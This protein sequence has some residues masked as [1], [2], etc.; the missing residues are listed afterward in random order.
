[1]GIYNTVLLK[2]IDFIDDLISCL[3]WRQLAAM[4]SHL[5]AQ[6]SFLYRTVRWRAQW[7][8]VW[9]R[10]HYFRP[11]AVRWGK[12]HYFR[13][14][15]VRWGKVHYFRPMAARWGKVRY[16]RQMAV[17]QGKTNYPVPAFHRNC[18]RFQV[19]ELSHHGNRSIPGL[20]RKR[21]PAA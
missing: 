11:M 2:D 10:A 6:C 13:Q 18:C 20:F 12:V 8:V 5:P 21:M 19:P 7:L 17:Q 15:A 1:M 4:S 16:C 14:M 3:Q 9:G